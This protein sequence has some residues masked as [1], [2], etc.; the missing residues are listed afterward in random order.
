M[1][2]IDQ[3]L[4]SAVQ[5][6]GAGRLAEAEAL[7]RGV[8]QEA[9]H[10]PHALHLLGVLAHQLGRHEEALGLIR[11]AIAVHGAHPVFYSNLAA[12]YLALGQLDET[13]RLAREALRLQPDLADAHNNLGVALMRQGH[14]DEAGAALGNAVRHDPRHTDARCNLG[15]VLHRQGKLP[16]AITLLEETVRLA[17][18]HAQAR[19]DLGGALLAA[20]EPI[21]AEAH[22]RQ[23]VRLRPGFAEAHSN[24]GLALREQGRIDEAVQSFRE[25][26]RLNPGYA[27]AHNN[28]GYTYEFHG[29]IDEARAEYQA[30]LRLDPNN[31]RALASLSGL[32]AA[33]HYELGDDE[34]R[35]IGQ[36]VTRGDLPLDDLGRL[37]FALARARDRAGDEDEAFEHYRRGNELRKEYVRR[38]GAAYDPVARRRYVDRLIGAFTPAY[39][40]RVAPFGLDTELPVFVVGMMRSG[41]SLAEQILA[42]HPR[43]HGAGELPDLDR[44]ALA[45]P[46]RLGTTEGYPECVA[47]LDAVV[48]RALAEEYLQGL[49]RRGKGADRVVDKLPFNFIHL[50]VIATLFPRARIIHCRRDPVD[51]CLSCFFQNFGEPHPFTLDLGHLGHYYRQYERLMAHW[52]RVLP[53]PV[54]ELN[55]EELT[56]DQEGVSRRL[57]AFCGLEWDERCLRFHETDRPVRTASALQV[58][59]PLYRSAVGRWKRYERHLGPLLAALRGDPMDSPNP[60]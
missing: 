50:G 29:K 36:L 54:F 46:Q 19:N 39:F 26:V 38:R 12:V 59:K 8:L 24:L 37:H 21:R 4:A 55:Y 10:H 3:R 27:G 60:P 42:S 33:G 5:H 14:F 40:E 32:A 18:G 15:A 9:P 44:L 22:L 2:T 28:L 48:A 31:P 47:R 56:A 20:G 41:T 34:L 6:H 11:S 1:L 17:P 16:E 30:A 57:V 25:A 7:Y 49:G 52:G 58:R 23:A 51:T 35:C 53:V 45:L 43:V 13:V